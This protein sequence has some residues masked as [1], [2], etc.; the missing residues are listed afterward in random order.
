[1]AK[2]KSTDYSKLTLGAKIPVKKIE[3]VA[4][5]KPVAKQRPQPHRLRWHQQRA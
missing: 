5:E 1:M 4:V 2:D 3:E